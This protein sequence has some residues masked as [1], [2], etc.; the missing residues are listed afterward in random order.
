MSRDFNLRTAQVF[1]MLPRSE[2][3]M[4]EQISIRLPLLVFGQ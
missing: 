4:V 3:R 2:M 1:P